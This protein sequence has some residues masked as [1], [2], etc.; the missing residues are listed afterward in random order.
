MKD[1]PINKM[2]EYKWQTEIHGLDP[3]M[4]PRYT[5]TRNR[6]LPGTINPWYYSEAA[7]D[8]VLGRRYPCGITGLCRDRMPGFIITPFPKK[9]KMLLM[10]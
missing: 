10:H 3:T 2:E 1:L 6:N 4:A 7:T 9:E 5:T 8:T